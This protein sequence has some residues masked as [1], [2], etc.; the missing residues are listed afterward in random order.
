MAIA[1]ACDTCGKPFSVKTKL[2]GKKIKCGNCGSVL[3][4]P[5][6]TDPVAEAA[7]G[8]DPDA[9]SDDGASD[10][11]ASDDGALTESGSD[12][13]AV[14]ERICHV[15]GTKAG[16]KATICVGCG[17]DLETGEQPGVDESVPTS[18]I[19]GAMLVLKNAP[20]RQLA[21]S[22]VVI[23][24][25]LIFGAYKL[26]V[27][28][29]LD[30]WLLAEG[31]ALEAEG[32]LDEALAKYDA[33]SRHDPS[34]VVAL[35]SVAAIAQRLGKDDVVRG[36]T[37]RII[38]S[39]QDPSLLAWAHATLGRLDYAAGK[40]KGA[41]AGLSKAKK[42]APKLT[43]VL[44]LE[45]HLAFDRIEGETDPDKKESFVQAA[46]EAYDA[47]I[48]AETTDSLTYVNRGRIANDF[49]Q[50]PSRAQE[51]LEE[52]VKV[53]KESGNAAEALFLLAEFS[54]L[55]EDVEVAEEKLRRSL[56]V[57]KRHAGAHALL[58]RILH[59]RGET[60]EAILEAQRAVD[61][62]EHADHQL[63]LGDLYAAT[64]R[65]DK[66]IEAYQK[67]AA[68]DLGDATPLLREAKLQQTKGDTKAA[69][70]AI[71]QAKRR[72]K[73]EDAMAL[74]FLRAE[75]YAASKDAKDHRTAQDAYKAILTAEPGNIRALVGEGLLLARQLG[76]PKGGLERVQRA[77]AQDDDSALAYVGLAQVHAILKDP[78]AAVAA[79]DAAI[80]RAPDD[81]EIVE[82]LFAF[83]ERLRCWQTAVRALEAQKKLATT[84]EAKAAI[85]V[86]IGELGRLA[87]L[88][89]DG[90]CSGED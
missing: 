15:C 28:V 82:Q 63:F 83:A 80:Q 60:D 9:P 27:S 20:R 2:A 45:G 86:K 87:F 40:T 88:Q 14:E 51:L 43:L 5:E 46:T 34:N 17:T 68:L 84:D 69:V 75:I 58:A 57:D 73:A 90:P 52:A 22:A 8:S 55:S 81:P 71:E 37:L 3:V 12:D 72:S 53:G 38:R 4:V 11:G 39:S 26:W 7:A 33:A 48:A 50:N 25:L 19:G 44:D 24:A 59:D 77:I 16:K 65:I 35:K 1:F 30:D 61:N 78:K 67:A 29:K 31:Q 54:Y 70:A 36:T 62:G 21:V 13:G 56:A 42:L 66:A 18:S 79:Y 74:N 64:D 32:I 41:T 85:D 10:D 6:A 49:E 23:S 47:A 76:K 89:G